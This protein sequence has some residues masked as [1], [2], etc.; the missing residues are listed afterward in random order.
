MESGSNFYAIASLLES[1]CTLRNYLKKK[2][3]WGDLKTIDTGREQFI[4]YQL[5]FLRIKLLIKG[6]FYGSAQSKN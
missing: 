3:P 6:F 1:L 4:L 5:E 2:S